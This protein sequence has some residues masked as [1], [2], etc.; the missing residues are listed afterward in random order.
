V[1]PKG[2]SGL[3]EYKLRNKTDWRNKRQAFLR[4]SGEICRHFA[5]ALITSS[6][7]FKS[8]KIVITAMVTHTSEAIRREISERLASSFKNDSFNV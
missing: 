1:T 8:Y 3:Y 7:T 2:K 4:T 5:E 6:Y